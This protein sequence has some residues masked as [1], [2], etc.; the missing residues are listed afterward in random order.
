MLHAQ[1][2]TFTAYSF[3]E[4]LILPFSYA[5]RA[6]ELG[7]RYLG[8]IDNTLSAYPSFS[9]CCH[10]EG[11]IP[12]FG[13]SFLLKVENSIPWNA[14]FLIKNEKGYCNLCQLLRRKQSQYTIEDILPFCEGLKLVVQVKDESFYDDY[15]LTLISP[16]VERIRKVYPEDFAFGIT[17]VSK[18]DQEDAKVFYEYCKNH[19]LDLICFPE[20][21]Y[22]HKNDNEILEILR[23]G[24]KK[25]YQ[26]T[27]E[28][29]GP[30]FLL[31]EKAL[32]SIYRQEEIENS[33][34]FV[35]DISFEFFE[36]RGALISVNND[37]VT[38]QEEANDGLRKRLSV[39][40][41]PE[42]YQKR[43]DYE[44]SVIEDMDFSSYFLIVEDYVNYA[45]ENGIKVGPGRGSAGGSLVSY[46]LGITDVNP[47]QYDLSFERFLN[48]K[49]KT[50]PDIDIDFDDKRRNEIVSYLVRKYTESHVSTIRTFVTLKPKSALQLF[51]AAMAIPESHI[52][53]IT[54]NISDKAKD[55]QEALADDYKGYRLK[56]VLEDPYYRNIVEMAER[57]LGIPVSTS[58]HAPGVIL[59]K[60]DISLT[61]PRAEGTLGAVEYE[62]PYME[63]MGFLKFDILPLSNLSF[64]K[65]I[66]DKI[67]RDGKELVDIQSHLDDP[68]VFR[69]L[70]QLSTC[71]IFQL[72]ATYGIKKAIQQIHPETFSDIAAILA[73]YRPGPMDY[74]PTYAKRK[75]HQEEVKY[76][77]PLLEPIL[78]E[79]Y[80]VMIYQEQVMK[81]VQA[82]A[83]FSASDADLFRRAISKKNLSKMKEYQQ[84]FLLGCK[85]N[86]I[87]EETALKIYG[88][89]EQFAGYGFNKSHAYAYAMITYQL[90]FYKVHDTKEFYTAAFQN[91]SFS[92]EHATKLLR[93]LNHFGI[94]A[95]LPNINLS[96]ENTIRI[97]GDAFY[98]PLSI[99]NGVDKKLI[100]TILKE[101][102][103]GKY[104]SFYDFCC[105]IVSQMEKNDSRSLLGL[106]DSGC[107]DS[108]CMYRKGMEE[109]LSTYLEFAR[110]KFD[111]NKIPPVVG[112]EENF[113]ERLI[114]EKAKNGLIL[115]KKISSLLSKKDYMT[116]IV[117]D[118]SRYETEHLL[119]CENESQTFTIQVN[120]KR[121]DVK[122]YDFV[123]VKADF[124]FKGRIYADDL[125]VGGKKVLK[126]V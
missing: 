63:R 35:S 38:L 93:E 8:I 36:K 53:K 87:T 23:A 97:E 27:Y 21:R 55:F 49:R 56:K 60:D 78:K 18:A 95:H 51:G 20:V 65:E 121:P 71:D 44:L 57:L 6:K 16:T 106:I 22:L 123:L 58:I 17:L 54:M 24:M 92:S 85:E 103:N 3:S 28:K 104:Q 80:G 96:F 109:N 88:D 30:Y 10:S 76:L 107:L 61:C 7:Y 75:N 41:L 29:E 11:L 46:A 13:Y 72:D 110:M 125:I 89:I 117:S 70:N 90:L 102:E 26:E 42:E 9:D 79:T 40:V 74:I 115:S 124:N 98:P 4:S 62:Y 99:L 111:E 94:H 34:R 101:R 105:R 52:K 15:Y 108:I 66:E 100:S 43:L 112:V 39:N 12:V 91:C 25:E 31:S 50:M 114:L 82:L 5:R 73:L 47:L 83:G 122:K 69:V 77:H 86:Q 48:P 126:Y 118:I 37:K 1:L 81:V 33:N 19:E 2:C 67:L 14:A 32:N 116:L 119:V 120:G 68:E 64:I 84:Q 113:G 59:S 45:K